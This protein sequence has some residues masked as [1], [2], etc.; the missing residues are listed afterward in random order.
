VP[1]AGDEAAEHR[2]S[3]GLLVDVKRLWVELLAERDHVI[4]RHVVR[5][6][7]VSLADLYLLRSSRACRYVGRASAKNATASGGLLFVEPALV[8]VSGDDLDFTEHVGW[9]VPQ[10]SRTV[11][12]VG[13]WLGYLGP[14]NVVVPRDGVALQPESGRVERVDQSE[15]VMCNT[16]GRSAGSTRRVTG[17]DAV[18][19]WPVSL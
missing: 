18:V 14:D 8:L 3:G 10:Y 2:L 19:S 12:Q 7:G 6:E 11:K 5:A 17:T 1:A 13:S 16:T 15:E 9:P 4:F